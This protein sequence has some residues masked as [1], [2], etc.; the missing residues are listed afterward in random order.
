MAIKKA[1]EGSSGFEPTLVPAYMPDEGDL[2]T[3]LSFTDYVTALQADRQCVEAAPGFFLI[4]GMDYDWP[5]PMIKC[6]PD[7]CQEDGE[8]A[9]DYCEIMIL[10]LAG[11]DEFS[12]QRAQDMKTYVENRYP[13]LTNGAIQGVDDY[14]L[15]QIFDSSVEMNNYVRR[16]DYG[17]KEVPKLA[18]GIVWEQG[19]DE[20]NYLYALRQ[21]STNFNYP[22]N[23]GRPAVSTTPDTTT[24]FDSYAKDDFSVCEPLDGV[25]TQGQEEYSCTGQVR[26][27][28]R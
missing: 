8:N 18:M 4:T 17:T 20:K 13:A 28:S 10:A 14:D 9:T 25:A 5:V 23:E 1:V 7:R 27:G 15:V 6:N 2:F 3:P 24:L 11:E 21:N 12:K 19:N 16:A 26:I 22:P